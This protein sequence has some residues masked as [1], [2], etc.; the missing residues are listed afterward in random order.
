MRMTLCAHT[1]SMVEAGRVDLAEA[2][3]VP[4][5]KA[6]AGKWDAELLEEFKFAGDD[7]VGPMAFHTLD[8]LF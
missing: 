8:D 1:L 5:L 6:F 4:A 7:A 2:V 3:L